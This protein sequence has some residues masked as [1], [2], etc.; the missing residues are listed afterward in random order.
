MK[1]T[2]QTVKKEPEISEDD[3]GEGSSDD[4]YSD[5]AN[6]ECEEESDD[7]ESSDDDNY[8]AALTASAI[9]KH[10][11]QN[12]EEESDDDESSDDDNDGAALTASAIEKHWAQ[13]SYAPS[14]QGEFGRLYNRLLKWI[15]LLPEEVRADCR[16]GNGEPQKPFSRYSSASFFLMIYRFHNDCRK[17]CVLYMNSESKRVTKWIGGPRNS[18]RLGGGTLTNVYVETC[19]VA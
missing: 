5:Y 4:D 3:S 15:K 6:S 7:D 17:L 13:N 11:A 8:G 12:C 1:R 14:T 9:K 18:R 16:I 2:R 19:F 10:W